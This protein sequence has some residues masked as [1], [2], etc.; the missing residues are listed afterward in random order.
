[1]AQAE[2]ETL[3]AQAA[4]GEIVLAYVDEAGFSQVHPNRSAWTP[5]GK[6]HLIEAKRGRAGGQIF[7]TCSQ[8][9]TNVECAC[10]A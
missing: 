1:M 7:S 4:A 5:T 2:I 9:G 8:M 10:R 6:R 3:R